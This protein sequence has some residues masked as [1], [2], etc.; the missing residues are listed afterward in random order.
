[1][2][3]RKR[4]RRRIKRREKREGEWEQEREFT[5][6]IFSSWMEEA[7]D[8]HDLKHSG[9]V[10]SLLRDVICFVFFC[11]FACFLRG[12]RAVRGILVQDVTLLACLPRGEMLMSFFSYVNNLYLPQGFQADS[13][14]SHFRHQG[15]ALGTEE[16]EGSSQDGILAVKNKEENSALTCLYP[17]HLADL[18]KIVLGYILCDSD[19]L[20][21]NFGME[22]GFIYLHI[23]CFSESKWVQT[24][25]IAL[26][27]TIPRNSVCLL[28]RGGERLTKQTDSYR[29]MHLPS[30]KSQ[31]LPTSLGGGSFLHVI[32]AHLQCSLW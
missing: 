21:L 14:S 30:N 7:I 26:S 28:V 5:G 9:R 10:S 1:M 15:V 18:Q 13:W 19:F 23:C 2:R 31:D 4:Q 29:V 11:L 12:K 25:A 3:R 16:T 8:N 20:S 17:H 24:F 22:L 6:P 27:L 32:L